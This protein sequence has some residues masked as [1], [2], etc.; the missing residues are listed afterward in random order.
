MGLPAIQASTR[1]KDLVGLG[2][3]SRRLEA[4]P[5]LPVTRERLLGEVR[6]IALRHSLAAREPA[7]AGRARDRT[8][9]HEV[10]RAS[11]LA[12]S[13]QNRQR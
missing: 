6:R 9:A 10:D 13:D 7:E 4:A 3:L 12:R 11:R 2:V 8:N 5:R 1:L